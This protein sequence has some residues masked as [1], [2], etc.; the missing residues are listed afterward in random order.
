MARSASVFSS[1]LP[2][3]LAFILLLSLIPAIEAQETSEKTVS[4]PPTAALP[5]KPTPKTKATSAAVANSKSDSAAAKARLEQQRAVAV[6]LLITL[7][8][9]V[10]NFNDQRLKART[11]ARIADALWEADAERGRVLFRKAW[12]AAEVADRE[13]DQKLQEEIRQQKTRTGGG[14][15][16]NLP[17]NLRREVLRLAARHDRALSE[18]FLEKLKAQKQ[19]AADSA[20]SLRRSSTGLSEALS[21]RLGLAEELL[22]AGDVDRAL[23]FADNALDIVSVETVNFL[24]SLR[25]KNPAAAD[26][27]YARMLANASSNFQSDANTV[28]LLSSYIF[29]PHL[30]LMFSSGGISSSQ[31]SSTSTPANVSPELRAAFFQ[32]GAGILLRPQPPPDQDQS[33]SGIDGKY[34]VLKRLMPLFEQFA[35]PNLAASMRGHL[36]ALS[37]AVSDRVRQRDDEWL[38]KGL[39]PENPVEDRDQEQVLLD[40][41]DRVRTSAE[42][43]ELYLELAFLAMRKGDMRAREFVRKIDE[44][45]LR[46]KVQA[47]IDAALA[48][49]AVGKK[50]TEQALELARNGELTHLQ[51][52]WVLTQSAKLLAKTDRDKSLA[53]LEDAAAEARRIDGSD[54]GRPRALMAVATVL[55]PLDAPLAW[56]A[57]F[58]AVK[59]ANSAEGFTG[60]DGELTL[61][62]QRKG[63]SS[64]YSNDVPDFDVAGIFAALAAEDYDRAV[65]LARGFQGEAPRATATIAI[66]RS[67]LSEKPK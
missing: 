50:Q 24:S 5:A 41:I 2:S 13:S 66:A 52:A 8:D 35:P 46:K 15:A 57:V 55:K 7:A 58:E 27:R 19:E 63:H 18:E 60:E 14:F 43:D 37:G 36:A 9:D 20:S 34:L 29:T 62:F 3:L 67:V 56:D 28:S 51:R 45:E 38:R 26:E 31:K 32:T 12:E 54:A 48:T 17:P 4:Q 44:S 59:A 22:A 64:V 53:L 21:Q 23:Q 49:D 16:I 61:R 30:Y 47:Y 39:K 65:Q 25:D 1:R 42:R 6:S 10:R 33:T 40:R 11:Q